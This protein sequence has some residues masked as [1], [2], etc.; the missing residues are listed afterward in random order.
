M[1]KIKCEELANLEQI[2]ISTITQTIISTGSSP[3]LYTWST[4]ENYEECAYWKL[5]EGFESA[6]SPKILRNDHLS[7]ISSKQFF[8]LN[9]ST[10]NITAN[11]RFT[12]GVTDYQIDKTLTY[13]MIKDGNGLLHLYNLQEFM[14]QGEGSHLHISQMDQ[15]EY[16]S[17]M[18]QEETRL[19]SLCEATQNKEN[20]K[21]TLNVLGDVKSTKFNIN[22]KST[23][24]FEDEGLASRGEDI[25]FSKQGVN[26][27]VNYVKE[28][29][30]V[31][32]MEID[33]PTII[34]ERFEPLYDASK[35]NIENTS[36]NYDKL[37]RMLKNHNEYP[38]K[39]RTLIWRYLLSLPLNREVFENLLKQ[40]VHPAFKDLRK[41]YPIKSERLYNKLLRVLSA[42]CYW[43]P[44]FSEVS[45]LPGLVF[46]FIKLI[47]SDDL[48]LFEI[49]ISILLQWCQN[50][51][52]FYPSEPVH[53][54]QLIEDLIETEDVDLYNH[55]KKYGFTFTEYAWPMVQTLFSEVLNGDTWAQLFDHIISFHHKPQLLY[56]FSAAY[57]LQFRTVILGINTQEEMQIFTRRLNTVDLPVLFK[58]ANKLHPKLQ[59]NAIEQPIKNYL[60][61]G[62][63]EY[64]LLREYP[65]YVVEHGKMLR[66][67][68]YEEEEELNRK[69][70]NI[71]EMHKR[72][73]ALMIKEQN[74]RSQ[75][76]AL[77]RA[78][79]ERANREA[80]EQD[81]RLNE[82]QSLNNQVK[83]RRM[84][85]LQMVETCIQN[86]LLSA[87]QMHTMEEQKLSTEY[88][89]RKKL[90]EFELNT[91]LEEEKLL[92][93]H[94]RETQKLFDLMKSR[95]QE[96]NHRVTAWEKVMKD[97]TE[98]ARRK[99]LESK[100]R[101]EDEER[102]IKHQVVRNELDN[103]IYQDTLKGNRQVE[104]YKDKIRECEREIKLGDIEQQRTIRQRA[105]NMLLDDARTITR[106]EGVGSNMPGKPRMTPD[107]IY[108]D[109]DS[110][111]NYQDKNSNVNYQE[112][113]S[114]I[115]YPE[116]TSAGF[117][118]KLFDEKR[119]EESARM[120]GRLRMLE[121]ERESM[122]ME[123]EK[124]RTLH[125][126]QE[127]IMRERE[128]KYAEA[129]AREREREEIERKLR[130]EDEVQ[131]RGKIIEYSGHK[132][133]PKISGVDSVKIGDLKDLEGSGKLGEFDEALAQT[134]K[135]LLS[136]E[137]SKYH[138]LRDRL[139]EEMG[140][141]G[142]RESN[143]IRDS[144]HTQIPPKPQNLQEERTAIIQSLSPGAQSLIKEQRIENIGEYGDLL[145]KSEGMGIERRYQ[146]YADLVGRSAGVG[147]IAD[148][149]IMN[150]GNIYKGNIYTRNMLES[151]ENIEGKEGGVGYSLSS[152]EEELIRRHE[153]SKRQ[154]QEFSYKYGGLKGAV[155]E[156]AD[157]NLPRSSINYSD[158]QTTFSRT[159][160]YIYIYI[161]IIDGSM[162][163]GLE[164]SS[165]NTQ[166]EV[167]AARKASTLSG[168]GSRVP[169]GKFMEHTK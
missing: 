107:N 51:F 41:K 115:N 85:H 46:P 65:K 27:Y 63:G 138:K 60:P 20:M 98:D 73:A 70:K 148:I 149:D 134:E 83:E 49:L 21:S 75:H 62:K 17:Y 10:K 47:E 139:K 7:F 150:Q 129:V 130:A 64:P 154:M 81:I 16:M 48:V 122:I 33:K 39:Y 42:L 136:S 163:S 128:N 38:K 18:T 11:L 2:D 169:T 79:N 69:R 26:D 145:R 59:E 19:A 165:V 164:S 157:V 92:N 12:G 74:I 105:E 80:E 124:E 86:N 144:V 158:S 146:G 44:I 56:S 131:L 8:L 153:E 84:E 114:N 40:G 31:M 61:L 168:P 88:S 91:K 137:S 167:S 58:L 25:I 112:K 125:E 36:L 121:N 141:M 140:D 109:K 102:L 45:Y 52:E 127:N 103:Q 143:Q 14:T 55:L 160:I 116:K 35:M 110:N 29:E 5:P 53:S 111:V 151:Q 43:C 152:K 132:R 123:L 3:F 101:A 30:K 133:Q 76:Q 104:E 66:E 32:E 161:Y 119:R 118:P 106:E 1:Q 77:L 159:H 34:P 117:Y 113:N 90:D 87:E 94:M 93:L 37:Q 57:L 54:L 4:Q 15:R 97:Q 71:V 22:N 68:I 13:L 142:V 24:S 166:S 95:D 108:T 100:W 99:T 156:S 155:S 23:N 120:N 147:E 50:W 6:K 162:S 135:K 82:K 9:M 78:Q 126:E 96:Q 89:S 28:V 67:K 72:T